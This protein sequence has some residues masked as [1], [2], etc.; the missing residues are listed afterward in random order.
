M[1][2]KNNKRIAFQ[3]AWGNNITEIAD[4]VALD[5]LLFPNNEAFDFGGGGGKSDVYPLPNY[6]RGLGGSTRKIPDIPGW[7]IL[8]RVSRYLYRWTE[9]LGLK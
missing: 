4:T 5:V 6:Q 2:L 9:V 8:S 3:T 1:G 7:P